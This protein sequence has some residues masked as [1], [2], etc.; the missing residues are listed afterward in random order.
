MIGTPRAHLTMSCE[1]PG[2]PALVAKAREMVRRT[3]A[4]WGVPPGALDDMVLVVSEL[5]GN[6]IAHGAPPVLLTLRAGDGALRGEVGDRGEARPLRSQAGGDGD[7]GRGLL[8]VDALTDR[9]GVRPGPGPDGKTVWFVR[10]LGR[11]AL[12]PS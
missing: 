3:L 12:R 2:D 4:E 11:P 1:L 9:W 6:A 8:I 5:V 7:R 10:L